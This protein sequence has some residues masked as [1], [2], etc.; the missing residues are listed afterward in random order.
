MIQV[1]YLVTKWNYP[2][3]GME[4]SSI[5]KIDSDPFLFSSHREELQVLV[6]LV[7]CGS[8]NRDGSQR[9]IY[10]DSWSFIGGAVWGG[11]KGMVFLEE[12]CH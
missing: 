9:L 3:V 4:T 2:A 8:L 11:L 6:W 5:L 7:Q 1:V 12:V 10:L